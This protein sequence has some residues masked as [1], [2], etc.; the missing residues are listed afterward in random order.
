VPYAVP[1]QRP[2]CCGRSRPKPCRVSGH[3]PA[4]PLDCC[5]RD[6]L[7]R[8]PQTVMFFRF[9]SAIV[10]VVL[11]SMAGVEIEKRILNLRRQISKQQYQTEILLEQH[12]ALRLRT[13]ELSSPDRMLQTLR[14][15]NFEPGTLAPS[16]ASG[17]T[18][19]T[20]RRPV[21]GTG[22][23]PYRRRDESV[24]THPTTPLP[25]MNWQLPARTRA[26]ATRSAQPF[27]SH[28]RRSR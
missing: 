27:R 21:S 4:P 7:P 1:I 6:S 9:I 25:L 20:A 19:S 23:Q 16:Q 26:G 13:Q 18:A 14:E 22:A 10:L 3:T 8:P 17:R 24:A 15:H 28:H 2:F 11:V 12:T 5:R